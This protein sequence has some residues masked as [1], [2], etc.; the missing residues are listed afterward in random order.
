MSAL[1]I[2]AVCIGV[3]IGAAV[4]FFRK[5]TKTSFCGVTALVT[6]LA[7]RA[8]GGAVKK[9]TSGYGLAMILSAVNIFK[10]FFSGSPTP[11]KII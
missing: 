2:I 10:I 5:F 1:L 8:L 6:V 9:T 11:T 4:G 7:V 3:A